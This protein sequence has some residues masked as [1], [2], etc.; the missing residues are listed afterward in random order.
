LLQLDVYFLPED[1][2]MDTYFRSLS[3]YTENWTQEILPGTI[4]TYII[5][6]A[7]LLVV[8]ISSIYYRYKKSTLK[9]KSFKQA[10]EIV[11]VKNQLNDTSLF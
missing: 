4:V 2:V 7:I 11:V 10:E 8:I 5:I 3:E 1:I 9:K 6:G